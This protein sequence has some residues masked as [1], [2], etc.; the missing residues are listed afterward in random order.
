MVFWVN[1]RLM[2][3]VMRSRSCSLI[4]A[5]SASDNVWTTIDNFLFLLNKIRMLTTGSVF[6]Y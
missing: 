3:Q 5:T 2:N 4:F 6:H 1:P